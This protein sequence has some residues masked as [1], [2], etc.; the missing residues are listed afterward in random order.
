M[1]TR[2]PQCSSVP[3]VAGTR[4]TLPSPGGT[5]AGALRPDTS[6][7]CQGLP[8]GSQA[9]CERVRWRML[10]VRPHAAVSS[11]RPSHAASHATV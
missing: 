2:A 11:G 6:Q 7:A 4:R 10:H 3:R 5:S 1:R 9:C 8:C